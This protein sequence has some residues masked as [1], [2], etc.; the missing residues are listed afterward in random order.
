MT[1]I[2]RAVEAEIPSLRRYAL[3]LARDNV[4]ADDL[5]QECLVRGLG[6]V[7]LWREGTNLR[8]WLCTILHNQYVNEI[9]RVT[10]KGTV[11]ELSEVGEMLACPP[12]QDK[13]LELRDVSR[14]LQALPKGQRMAVTMI[15]IDGLGY[16]KVASMV[17]VSVGTV[18]SRL[19]RGRAKLRLAA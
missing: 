13:S 17:G 6:N 7:H 1:D 3:K 19:S 12:A 4:L 10:R 5:L 15:G 8:A 18:R 9:R 14:A 2:R 16:E 11:I